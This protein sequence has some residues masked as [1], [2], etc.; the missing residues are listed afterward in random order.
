MANRFFEPGEQRV[1]RVK[2]LFSQIASRYDLLNDLQSLGLHRYWKRRLVQL[3][4]PQPGERALD[5][6]CGTGDLTLAL[7]CSGV[8]T[9]GLDFSEQMLELARRKVEKLSRVQDQARKSQGS[10]LVPARFVRGDALGAPFEDS[11]FNIVTMGY[12]LRNLSDWG[13]GLREMQRVASPGGRVLVLDFGKPD[14]W[15]WRNLYFGY[16]RMVV[17]CLGWLFCGD[18]SAYAYILESLKHYPAQHGVAARM[19]ELG[20]VNVRI[21]SFWHGIMT[22]N[23]GE[24]RRPG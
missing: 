11:A 19:R 13:E 4:A 22:I 17:P 20:L 3:A 1:G 24:K 2:D 6:C 12:G 21:V 15:L 16:L 10:T 7:T 14:N 23:Y 8:E 5:L 18:A 9:V